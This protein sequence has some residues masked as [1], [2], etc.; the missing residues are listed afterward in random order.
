MHFYWLHVGYTESTGLVMARPKDTAL[1]D[2]NQAHHLTVG[3]IDRLMCPEGIAGRQV[4]LRDKKVSG[5]KV[6][7]TVGG[8]KSFVFESKLNGKTIRRTIGSVDAWSIEQARAEACRLRVDVDKG[9]DP[10]EVDKS[11]EAARMAKEQRLL[12]EATTVK[13]LWNSYLSDRHPYWSNNH[14]RDHIAMASMGGGD[15]KRWKNRKTVSGPLAELMCK[16]LIDL[17]SEDLMAWAKKESSTR[18]SSTR[19]ALRHFKAFWRW[20]YEQKEYKSL[21][22]LDVIASRRLREITGSQSPKQDYLQKTQ[23]ESWF[24]YVT[25]I[26][27]RIISVYL[28]CLLLTG[29]RREELGKLRWDDINFQWKSLNIGDKND[30][31]RPIPLT[32]YV[33]YLLESLPRHNE[34]VFSSP[35][36][37][38]G[39]LVN[40]AKAH[41]QACQAAGVNVS[42][43]GLR[44]S[45][46]SLTEWLEIPVGIVA[47]IMGHKPSA[48]AEKH[49]TV[50]PLDLLA[51][52]HRSIEAWILKEANISYT[53]RENKLVLVK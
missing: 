36:S 53:P 16:R 9:L 20:A 13:T 34:W 48:T 7:A 4:F 47:Q 28:Q 42:L 35:L 29:A 27:N 31:S 21:I 22:D 12:S 23:L 1:I 33:E 25:R 3:K 50:R 52:H 18:P 11:R 41:R 43:H 6:R 24:G 14:Y 37:E 17:T 8:K 39:R 15:R 2:F 32:T 10:R 46:K 45:F 26:E 49:Y 44:R 38:S 5:L 19:L 40:P 51:K 30:G